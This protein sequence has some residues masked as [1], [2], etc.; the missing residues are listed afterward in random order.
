MPEPFLTPVSVCPPGT[1]NAFIPLE[2]A[3]ELNLD[4]RLPSRYVLLVPHINSQASTCGDVT[5]QISW[6]YKLRDRSG[7]TATIFRHPNR[8]QIYDVGESRVTMELFAGRQAILINPGGTMR[9]GVIFP[10]PFGITEIQASG[11]SLEDLLELA[12]LVAE[13]TQR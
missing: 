6:T 7:V 11:M 13:A 1:P 10:E 4:L 9:S 5:T 12:E 3:G 2:E 8:R